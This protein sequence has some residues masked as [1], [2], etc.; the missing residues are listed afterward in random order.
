V[1]DREWYKKSWS[2]HG[3]QPRL[4][5]V[6]E[7]NGPKNH[8]VACKC[9][10][11]F[12]AIV[13]DV[14]AF[15][16]EIVIS[17]CQHRQSTIYYYKLHSR[18]PLYF[19]HFRSTSSTNQETPRMFCYGWNIFSLHGNVVRE[20]SFSLCMTFR[21]TKVQDRNRVEATL[22]NP[23]LRHP[24]N[25]FTT[26][27]SWQFHH[28]SNVRFTRS[29]SIRVTKQ[30]E[31]VLTHSYIFWFGSK[32]GRGLFWASGTRRYCRLVCHLE[33]THPCRFL[34]KWM[35]AVSF[36]ASTNDCYIV[37]LKYFDALTW[38][39]DKPFSGFW[40]TK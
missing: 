13:S 1:H 11:Q 40:H 25:E 3:T 18:V 12:I 10:C 9:A 7:E 24:A 22:T 19:S 8:K 16:H 28:A 32:S 26:S 17:D 34:K 30:R 37:S 29:R 21:P 2:A 4:C 39:K 33:W 5:P 14:S 31:T 20:S 27:S 38:S 23:L 36:D 6:N 35:I 15:V